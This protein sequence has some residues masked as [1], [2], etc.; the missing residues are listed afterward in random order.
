[1]IRGSGRAS[2]SASASSASRCCGW[3]SPTS[4]SSTRTTCGS[5]SNSMKISYSWLKEHIALELSAKDLSDHLLRLGFEVVA[6][7][8]L[9]PAFSGVVTAQVLEVSKHPNADRLNLCVVDD[10]AQKLSI[11]C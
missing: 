6:I 11:V 9:G 1:M 2:R 5:S 4:A 7:E 8:K 3:A 10:G